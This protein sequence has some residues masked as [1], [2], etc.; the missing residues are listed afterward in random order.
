MIVAQI[1]C[2]HGEMEKMYDKLAEWEQKNDKTID[3]VLCC[4]DF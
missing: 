2:L 4:G 3:V 1:G